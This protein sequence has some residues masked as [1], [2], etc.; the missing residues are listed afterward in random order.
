LLATKVVE[1][2]IEGD[3]TPT[4][5]GVGAYRMEFDY[6]ALVTA[7]QLTGL[8][9]MAFAG[10]MSAGQTRGHVFAALL[11]HHPKVSLEDAGRLLTEGKGP[12]MEALEE[13]YDSK[14]DDG[15]IAE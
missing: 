7:E 3:T 9:L 14:T 10:G 13:L 5:A 15:K 11:K 4:E 2:K 1:F 12:V 6:N 8:N